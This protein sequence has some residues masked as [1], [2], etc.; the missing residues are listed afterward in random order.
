MEDQV[1]SMP[2]PNTSDC[3]SHT[4]ELGEVSPS[5]VSLLRSSLANSMKS[6]S[7]AIRW[8]QG[9]WITLVIAGSLLGVA[10]LNAWPGVPEHQIRL[11]LPPGAGPASVNV[12][13]DAVTV[14]RGGFKLRLAEAGQV[15]L[16]VDAQGC[17]PFGPADF[18]LA[19]LRGRDFAIELKQLP[20]ARIVRL[21]IPEGVDD[22]I[23]EVDGQRV[24]IEDSRFT[25]MMVRG[26]SAHIAVTAEGCELLPAKGYTDSDL[27]SPGFVL[28][29]ER[30]KPIPVDR[31]VRIELPEGTGPAKAT[32]DGMDIR[33]QRRD[34]PLSLLPDQRVRIAVS[35]PGCDTIDEE[36]S[37]A[38]LDRVNSTLTLLKSRPPSPTTGDISEQILF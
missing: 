11:I 16:G 14:D 25:V 34:F 33:L 27:S 10:L 17:E 13:G 31:I 28:K 6:A 26:Q 36:Y 3:T 12:N 5:S 9:G 24:P 29:L 22:A 38:D 1:S 19:D 32:I 18:T 23:V 8:P 37:L 20:V 2:E 4:E 15:R 30:L 7:T 21:D 35:A